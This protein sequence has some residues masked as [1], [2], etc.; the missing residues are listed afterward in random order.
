MRDKVGELN[1]LSLNND[2]FQR[3]KYEKK[4]ID[5]MDMESGTKEKM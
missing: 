2:R 4:G 5:E 3:S 1:V